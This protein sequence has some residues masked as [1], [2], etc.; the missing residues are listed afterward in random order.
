VQ[1]ETFFFF[2]K[3]FK[4]EMSDSEEFESSESEEEETNKTE[5]ENL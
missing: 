3:C 1:K 2:D 5:I 4:F